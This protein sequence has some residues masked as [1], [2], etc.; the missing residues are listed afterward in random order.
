MPC[1]RVGR[2]TLHGGQDAPPTTFVWRLPEQ[3]PQNFRGGVARNLPNWLGSGMERQPLTSRAT[4]Y[5]T[6]RRPSR[7]RAHSPNCRRGWPRV[8]P[9]IIFQ[10]LSTPRSSNG[11][12]E[13]QGC[14]VAAF[15]PDGDTK[16]P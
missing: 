15:S 1:Q 8:P 7:G 6:N 16:F 11:L 10:D 12:W 13:H 14:R 2:T 4:D 9:S 3:T 5:D